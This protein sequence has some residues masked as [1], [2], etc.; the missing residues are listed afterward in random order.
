MHCRFYVSPYMQMLAWAR[1]FNATVYALEHRF[2]GFSQPKRSTATRY[3]KWLTVEQ[4]LADTA[5]FIQS[6]NAWN[7]YTNPKWVA[8]GGS[9]AGNLAAWFRL[10]YPD[11]TVGAV[12]SSAP[13]Q[14]KTDYFG[15]TTPTLK[16]SRF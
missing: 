1:K 9:Y 16:R 7:N 6:V 11:L 15:R 14:V 2:Y 5:N 4:A 8:F 13:V 10:K 3:L 12:A